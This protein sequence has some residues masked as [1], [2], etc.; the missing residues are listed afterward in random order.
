MEYTIMA[1]LQ[2]CLLHHPPFASHMRSPKHHR[3]ID[4]L[5][6]HWRPVQFPTTA[7]LDLQWGPKAS[8]CSNDSLNS[9][10][11]SMLIPYNCFFGPLDPPNWLLPWQSPQEHF[12]F[13]SNIE[14]LTTRATFFWARTEAHNFH[15]LEPRNSFQELSSSRVQINL[16]GRTYSILPLCSA[17]KATCI[18]H[19]YFKPPE[20]SGGSPIDCYSIKLL[21]PLASTSSP[22]LLHSSNKGSTQGLIFCCIQIDGSLPPFQSRRSPVT[23]SY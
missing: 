17:P 16:R 4:R 2:N 21:S 5:N 1:M 10:R 22:E 20:M 12:I 11:I 6:S 3:L 13:Q 9:H 15:L 8:S 14:L 23:R 7:P 19:P 18:M